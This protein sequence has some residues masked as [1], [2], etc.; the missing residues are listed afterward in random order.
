[1]ADQAITELSRTHV[2]VRRHGD[3]AAEVEDAGSTNGTFVGGLRVRRRELTAGTI[4]RIGSTLF[5]ARAARRRP[6]RRCALL[7]SSGRH[8]SAALA[9]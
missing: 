6:R 3:D 8:R 5:L 4:L 1:M 7:C 2:V 9:G